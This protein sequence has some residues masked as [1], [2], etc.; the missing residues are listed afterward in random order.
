M[1]RG[2]SPA[3][4][5]LVPVNGSP[6]SLA[7]VRSLGRRDINVVAA[8][9]RP[10]RPTLASRY[11][12]ELVPVTSVHEDLLAYRDALVALAARSDVRAVVPCRE[13]DAYLL[14][15]YADEFSPHV[16]ELWQPP[17]LLRMAH[18]GLRLAEAAEASGVPVPETRLLGDVED[19]DRRQ[20]VKPRYPLR[21]AGYEPT[22]AESECDPIHEV[23]YLDPGVEPDRQAL[24]DALLGHEPLVQQFVEKA[25]EYMVAALYDHGDPVATFQHRQI[26]GDS[27]TGGG[28]VYRESVH[29]PRLETVARRLLDHL[30]WHGLACIEFM[31]D[32]ETGEFVLTEINPRMWRSLPCTVRAGAD[33]PHYYWLLATGRRDAI[34]PTYESGV[35]SH[36]LYGELEYLD[37]VAR[38]DCPLVDRPS[39]PAASWSVLSSLVTTPRFDYFRWDDPRPFARAVR[40]L[41]PGLRAGARRRRRSGN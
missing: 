39:L 4:S 10:E 26:R 32:A 2:R 31:E 40:N 20:V 21:V 41:V 13:E 14:S 6:S 22:Y 29:L 17:E 19:W 38:T 35:R 7:C 25:D 1:A 16:T 27:Y 33:F 12:D 15:R 34:D 23:T 30:D 36:L 28:S 3:R 37:S 18:D 9:E 8:A 5:V 11:C 24:R